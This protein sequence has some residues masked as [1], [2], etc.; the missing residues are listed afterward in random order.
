MQG[1]APRRPEQDQE[2]LSVGTLP[3]STILLQ[4]VCLALQVLLM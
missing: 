2:V 3:W 4:L 1:A